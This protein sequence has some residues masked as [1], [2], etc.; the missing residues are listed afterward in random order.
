MDRPDNR[1]TV[2]TTAA[3]LVLLLASLALN[4]RLI[5]TVDKSDDV[6][7]K[8]SYPYPPIDLVDMHGM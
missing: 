8:Q 3:A 4:A 7:I 6:S 5:W 1:F 2:S